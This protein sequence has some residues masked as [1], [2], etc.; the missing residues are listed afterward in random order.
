M[1]RISRRK[2]QNW[3]NT[4]II[5]SRLPAFI[6]VNDD[7]MSI[8]AQ[9]LTHFSHKAWIT[10]PPVLR[11]RSSRNSAESSSVCFRHWSNK[12]RVEVAQR[13]LVRSSKS[14]ARKRTVD[15]TSTTLRAGWHIVW[16]TFDSLRRYFCSNSKWFS[17]I[18]KFINQ[19]NKC[20]LPTVPYRIANY[21]RKL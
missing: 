14:L 5:M 17:V 19:S 7:S 16:P 6:E 11:G 12:S 9:L 3:P 4:R 20:F 1:A 15:S 13:G 10:G 21:N 2:R 18:S 8:L